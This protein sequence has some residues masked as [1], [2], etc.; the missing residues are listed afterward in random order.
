M[1]SQSAGRSASIIASSADRTSSGP[2]AAEADAAARFGERHEVDRRQLDA[3]LRVAE[4]HHLLP[5]DHAEH[6]VLDHDDL[7]RQLVLDTN[8]TRSWPG[9]PKTTRMFQSMRRSTSRS[10]AFMAMSLPHC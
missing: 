1:A 2:L 3:V 8:R 6:V 5:L 7:D 4:E 10:A 9:R